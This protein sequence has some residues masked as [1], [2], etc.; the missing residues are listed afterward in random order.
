VSKDVLNFHF[1]AT[2]TTQ[3]FPL[4]ERIVCSYQDFFPEKQTRLLQLWDETRL[5]LERA[6]QKFRSPLTIIGF[7]ADPNR[8]LAT[9][10]PHKKSALVAELHCSGVSHRRW[11]A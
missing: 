3:K 7:D 9:L 11:V 5:P 8:M 6:K 1:D 10:P 4:N 2:W